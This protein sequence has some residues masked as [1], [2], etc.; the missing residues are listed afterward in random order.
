MSN[1]KKINYLDIKNLL[2]SKNIHPISSLKDNVIFSSLNSLSKADE[3]EGFSKKVIVPKINKKY[4]LK[5]GAITFLK[6]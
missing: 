6:T 4:F 5:V 2:V 1:I 3:N